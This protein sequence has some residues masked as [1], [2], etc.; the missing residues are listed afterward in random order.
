VPDTSRFIA[1][2]HR[3]SL[4]EVRVDDEG[5]FLIFPQSVAILGVRPD[6]TILFVSQFRKAAGSM[7]IEL[8]GGRVEAGE[9][10][11]HAVR[12]ELKEESGFR[13][14][15]I[16]RILTLDLD[17]SIS[18]HQTLVFFGVLP[19]KPV[20]SG[21][22]TFRFLTLKRALKLVASGRITHA[23]SVAALLWLL[24]ELR[25]TK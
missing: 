7:T 10:P 21:S 17:F 13:A 19:V 6:S 15:S 9:T 3:L 14:R 1:K 2:K 18:R 4:S 24:S 12:R 25:G 23:P 8:P 22:F 20:V 5:A 11:Q 16:R